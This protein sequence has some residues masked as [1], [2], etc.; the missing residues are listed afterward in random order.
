M[1]H[2]FLNGIIAWSCRSPVV[3]VL[4]KGTP[5]F[6]NGEPCEI[7]RARCGRAN[8]LIYFAYRNAG[9]ILPKAA[10]SPASAQSITSDGDRMAE[11]TVWS[12]PLSGAISLL[13]GNLTGKPE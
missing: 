2:E 7:R 9:Q 6:R 1:S 8:S 12:E 11:D 13:T 5:E 3:S 10:Q 4:R